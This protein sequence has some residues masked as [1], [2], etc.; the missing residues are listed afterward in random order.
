MKCSLLVALLFKAIKYA[1]SEITAGVKGVFQLG[2][3]NTPEFFPVFASVKQK[4]TRLKKNGS[5]KDDGTF[6]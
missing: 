6:N 3:S 2:Q 1:F 5:F 4:T